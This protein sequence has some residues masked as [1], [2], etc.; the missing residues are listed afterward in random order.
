MKKQKEDGNLVLKYLVDP[1]KQ[2]NR[3]ILITRQSGMRLFELKN[4]PKNITFSGIFSIEGKEL[5]SLFRRFENPQHTDWENKGDPQ[6]RKHINEVKQWIRSIIQEASEAVILDSSEIS[7]LSSNL[8]SEQ[9][10]SLIASL[11][12]NSSE[13]PS[14]AAPKPKQNTS[15]KENEKRFEQTLRNVEIT[16]REE[17]TSTTGTLYRSGESGKRKKEKVPGRIDDKGG[18]SGGIRS[19]TGVQNRSKKEAHRA[20]PDP[21]GRDTYLKPAKGG[22]QEVQPIKT[23]VIKLSDTCYRVNLTLDEN[24]QKG[25]I[26]I[27]TV[28]EESGNYPL[29]VLDPKAISGCSLLKLKGSQIHFDYLSGE[30]KVRFDFY[31]RH[32]RHYAMKVNIYES[33]E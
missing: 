17:R 6:N 15:S 29:Q 11:H 10:G 23:R 12:Q 19:T 13:S 14:R 7:G 16:P 20:L 32:S 9:N 30:E 27:T 21:T 5:N 1:Q 28:G 22:V 33:G 4:L 3:K 26:E 18:S 25:Y 8:N 24:L 2:L 31:L